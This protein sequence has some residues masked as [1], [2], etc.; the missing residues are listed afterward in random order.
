MT[1][2]AEQ[3]LIIKHYEDHIQQHDKPVEHS[4]YYVVA[5]DY[6]TA[7]CIEYRLYILTCQSAR[8]TDEIDLRTQKLM[9]GI[10]HKR[11]LRTLVGIAGYECR[12]L[13]NLAYDRRQYEHTH[14][15]K[16]KQNLEQRHHDRKQ[17]L[18]CI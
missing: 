6:N 7:E 16:H 18:A 8:D 4:H 1:E 15:H 17:P 5:S 13:M 14:G 9:Q 2:T 11:N 12:H 3:T 10:G